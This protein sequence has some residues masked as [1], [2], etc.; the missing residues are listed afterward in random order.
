MLWI[1]GDNCTL[2]SSHVLAHQGF[3][4]L[5]FLSFFYKNLVKD[6]VSS[7][8]LTVGVTHPA[9]SLWFSQAGRL[10]DPEVGGIQPEPEGR[11]P[12]PFSSQLRG[13]GWGW[14]GQLSD[15]AL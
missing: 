9:L 3:C 15:Q 1:R 2:Q 5:F 8:P 13:P 4:L 11:P 6:H 10:S 14:G 7:S 12:A